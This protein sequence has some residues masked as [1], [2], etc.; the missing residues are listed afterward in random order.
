[1]FEDN[2]IGIPPEEAEK[3]FEP[4]FRG[5]N[6]MSVRGSG[7]GLSLVHKIIGNHN[8]TVKLRSETGKGS[9]FTIALPAQN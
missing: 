8:G 2:G 3:V 5:S 9:V 6:T 1:V 4:F 7:I